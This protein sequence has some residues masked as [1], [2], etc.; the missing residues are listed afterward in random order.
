MLFLTNEPTKRARDT[1][2]PGYKTEPSAPWVAISGVYKAACITC[3]SSRL[4]N[5]PLFGF[6]FICRFFFRSNLFSITL[7]SP[8]GRAL[9]LSLSSY[10]DFLP[11][12]FPFRVFLGSFFWPLS[13]RI[14]FSCKR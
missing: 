2:G 14:C 12:L 8:V 10:P 7:L 9:S 1:T 5:K 11:A 6:F 13:D 3:T 4:L